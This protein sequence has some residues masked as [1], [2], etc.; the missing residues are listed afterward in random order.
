MTEIAMPPPTR[1]F[2]GFGQ[3]VNRQT[4]NPCYS[5]GQH[6][7]TWDNMEAANGHIVYG[8]NICVCVQ[9]SWTIGEYRPA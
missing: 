5:S 7:A 3:H 8:S 1:T 2:A 4:G 6:K 9:I